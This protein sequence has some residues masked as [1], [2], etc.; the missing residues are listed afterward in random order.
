M[1]NF[2]ILLGITTLISCGDSDS[3]TTNNASPIMDLG[4]QEKVDSVTVVPIST[5]TV[6]T[7]A[8][9]G[10]D[11]SHYQGNIMD[12]L[13]S[14]DSI[15]FVFCKA[16]QGITYTDPKFKANWAEIKE[17]NIIRGAYHFYVCKDSPVK[18]AKHFCAAIADITDADIA[19]VLDI[20]QGG[21]SSSVDA[22][23][24]QKDILTFLQVVE[25]LTK[26]RPILYTD[27][28]FSQEFLSD[29]IFASYD[30][31]LAEYTK[32]P[33]PKVPTLWKENGFKIWQKS[34]SYHAFSQT[35]DFDVYYGSLKDLVK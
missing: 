35:I 11:I 19:P 22:K 27:H 31:W 4:D 13:S 7:T 14:K 29:T 32:A 28:A 5:P 33:T 34:A 8:H 24:M 25:K 2:L 10:I 17:K 12:K 30:L 3:A 9:Y 23:Q 18:Q 21:M 15:E 26:R 16:T 20:E 1:K 6:D